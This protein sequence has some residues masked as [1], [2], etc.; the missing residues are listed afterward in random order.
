MDCSDA[1][2]GQDGLCETETQS[3]PLSWHEINGE[4]TGR[5]K[6]A[7]NKSSGNN[8]ITDAAADPTNA[9]GRHYL[10]LTS[11][12]SA[13]P[14]KSDRQ[15]AW[16]ASAVRRKNLTGTPKNKNKKKKNRKSYEQRL[17][18]ETEGHK[19]I[20]RSPPQER[21]K[22]TSTETK[23]NPRKPAPTQADDAQTIVCYPLRAVCEGV[24]AAHTANQVIV[25][26]KT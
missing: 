20:P 23:L 15:H 21:K 16:R 12:S 10:T 11:R 7:E 14:G 1:L 26:S 5:N 13:A 22:A 3:D 2:Y 17:L 4:G 24:A 18:G 25:K 19:T 9:A 8:T 6:N